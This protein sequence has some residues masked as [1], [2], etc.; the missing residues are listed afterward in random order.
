M[1]LQLIDYTIFLFIIKFFII[2][3]NICFKNELLHS[4]LYIS[5]NV[6]LELNP[7]CYSYKRYLKNNN[8]I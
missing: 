8:Y 7:Y 1:F 6:F 4:V 3:T 2:N 5:N